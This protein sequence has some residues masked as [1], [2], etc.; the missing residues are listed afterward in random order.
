MST[1]IKYSVAN[2]IALVCLSRSDRHNALSPLM[3]RMLADLWP[4]I[5]LNRDVRALVLYGDG[6]SFCSGMDLKYTNP[7]FGYREEIKAK[8]TPEELAL[9]NHYEAHPG[10]RRKLNYIP[11]SNFNKPIISVLQGNIRGGGLELAL[12]SDIRLAT[13]DATFGFPEVTRGV[14]AASGGMVLLPQIIGLGRA[15]ELLLTGASIDATEAY[16]IGLINKIVTRDQILNKAIELAEKIANNAPLAV[17]ATKETTL[18]AI[19]SAISEGFSISENQARNL[20]QTTDYQEGVD[21]F[22]EKRIPKFT[23]N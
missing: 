20:L 11:P 2:H 21:A 22:V 10:E 17:Q 19:G 9:A 12:N 14:A 8:I 3:I 16:R 6:S 1:P 23:G 5:Q 7:G 4:E 15:M 13:E 18:R